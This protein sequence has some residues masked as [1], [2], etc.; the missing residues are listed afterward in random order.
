MLQVE[1]TFSCIQFI[2]LRV[3]FS[4]VFVFMQMSPYLNMWLDLHVYTQN[5]S[6]D[7]K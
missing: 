3:Y 2:F 4:S 7:I 5:K 1:N 6:H